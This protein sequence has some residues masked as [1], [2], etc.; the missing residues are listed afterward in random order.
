MHRA[1]HK[2][3]CGKWLWWCWIGGRPWTGDDRA[4][5]AVAGR[6]YRFGV[7]QHQVLTGWPPAAVTVLAAQFFPSGSTVLASDPSPH[8]APHVVAQVGK[9]RRRRTG[10][11]VGA[12]TTQY[13]SESTEQLIQ[14]LVDPDLSTDRLHLGRHRPQGLFGRIGVD[15]SPGGSPFAVAVDPPPEEIQPVID[16]GDQRLGHGQAQAH[17]GQDSSDALLEGFGVGL[18]AVDDPA[19][20]VR[21]PDQPVV[22]Q[23][24]TT[25]FRPRRCGAARTSW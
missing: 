6:A 18:G 12:P 23:T 7:E 13:R 3:R 24:M 22:G 21:I 4:P 10:P 5:V 19:P 25:P 2:S 11:E 14:W 9:R 16:V 8:R 20:V 1:L 15:E 17:R